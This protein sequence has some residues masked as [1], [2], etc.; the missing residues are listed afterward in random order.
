VKEAG[1]VRSGDAPAAARP[2]TVGVLSD[3]HGHLYPS[4]KQLLAGVDHIIHAGDVGSS[5]VLAELRSIAPV[6]AV[7]G[8]CD[9][10]PWAQALPV[11]AEVKLGGVRILVGHIAGQLRETLA[12]SLPGEARHDAGCTPGRSAGY[13]VVV[14]GHSHLAAIEERGGALHVNP[15]SAGPR[16]FGRSQTVARLTIRPAAA[17]DLG[18]ETQIGAEIL[19]AAGEG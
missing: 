1:D 3:T 12:Q 5:Q 8:N 9:H 19:A 11:R 14:T 6:T 17:G 4:V 7:R 16:Q 10:E 13:A 15:G 2:V 18:S